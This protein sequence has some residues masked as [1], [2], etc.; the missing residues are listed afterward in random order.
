M[1]GATD[2]M[3]FKE[4]VNLSIIRNTKPEIKSKIKLKSEPEIVKYRPGVDISII[5][6]TDQTN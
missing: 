2:N 4:S 3:N 6:A 1:S 5:R